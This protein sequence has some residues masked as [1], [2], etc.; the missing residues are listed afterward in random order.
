MSNI[1]KKSRRGQSLMELLIGMAVGA[2]LIIGSAAIITSSLQENGQVTSVEIQ[3]QLGEELLNNTKAWSQGNWSALLALATGT[4]NTYYLNTASSPFSVTSS[5]ESIVNNGV[6]FNRSFYINDVYRDNNGNVT[7]TV[8]GNFYDPSTKLITTT[9]QVS[10]ST[11]P[12]TSYSMYLTRNNANY[13]S[14]QTWVGGSGFTAPTNFVS[15]TYAQATNIAINAQGGFQ[16][17]VISGGG[18]SPYSYSRTISVSTSTSIASGTNTNFPM[19]FSGTYSWLEASSSGG[20][21]Q[22]LVTAPNGGQEPADLVFTTDSACSS[23]LNYETES[24]TSSTGAIVDWINVPSLSAGS[25][26]YACYDASSITTDQSH[27]SSTWNSNYKLVMHLPT[28]TSILNVQ[29]STG[30]SVANTN[31]GATSDSSGKIDGAATVDGSTQYIDNSMT[32]NYANMSVDFWFYDSNISASGNPRIIANSHTDSDGHGF[33]IYL[34]SSATSIECQYGASGGI[35][36]LYTTETIVNNTWYHVICTYD[37]TNANLYFDGVGGP[38]EFSASGNIVAS[39]YDVNEGRNPAYA[40]DYFP[41]AID[42]VRILSTTLSPSWALTEYNN[43]NSPSTFYAV[44]SEQTVTGGG[45]SATSNLDSQPLD[46]HSVSG[47]ELNSFVWQGT[48]PAGTTVKFQFA[49]SNASSGPWTF[50]GPDGTA[51][52]YFSGTI[53]T[54]INLVSTTNGYTLFNG[55]RYFSYRATLSTT[56]GSTPTVSEISVNWS[57]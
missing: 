39:G 53:G 6:T 21:I 3:A 4:S 34:T 1:S 14:Q 56:A 5:V 48:Q 42:E 7:T 27:P 43:E 20:R 2:V 17:S 40:G 46:T 49:V 24:Y 15:S 8:S 28:P 12:A 33:Q 35:A 52:T 11:V 18:P 10:S 51:N 23:T 37:G 31:D 54:P 25:V 44:G 29:D 55:Y 41:G 19:L 36:T 57:P 32:I 9:V 38:G 16:I 50:V 45:G 13:F 26:I 22:N 30:N 47:V